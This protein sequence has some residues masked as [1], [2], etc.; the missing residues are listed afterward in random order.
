MSF[1]Y[2]G[3]FVEMEE[4]IKDKEKSKVSE[5][6]TNILE[7]LDKIIELL[8]DIKNEIKGG[9]TGEG[10]TGGVKAEDK[11]SRAGAEQAGG[12]NQSG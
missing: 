12:V 5:T 2:K 3:G 9:V 11:D 1:W 10:N 8:T 7:K 6:E 4:I